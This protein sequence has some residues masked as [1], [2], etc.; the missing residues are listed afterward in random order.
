M[1]PFSQNKL[2]S[3]L[4]YLFF[5][6]GLHF[7]LLR[8][9]FPQWKWNKSWNR[10]SFGY[11]GGF[12]MSLTQWISTFGDGSWWQGTLRHGNVLHSQDPRGREAL[13]RDQT[14]HQAGS[15][16][17]QDCCCCW[18]SSQG[19]RGEMTD[20]KDETSLPTGCGAARLSRDKSCV[21][22]SDG[23]KDRNIMGHMAVI[24]D[25]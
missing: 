14:L 18:G 11:S 6:N 22:L 16:Q 10:R 12:S 15:Q 20:T 21:V 3:Y 1:L 2:V 5:L 25:W 9:L 4:F 7:L 24:F 19:Q 8:A 17:L 23:V 13:C